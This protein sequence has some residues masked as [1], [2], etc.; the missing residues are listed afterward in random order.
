M[1]ADQ[2]KTGTTT[3]NG[4]HVSNVMWRLVV[5]DLD[6]ASIVIEPASDSEGRPNGSPVYL[7]QLEYEPRSM[8]LKFG[9]EI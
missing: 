6:T 9:R 5:R 8:N 2:C 4:G 1:I 3:M 7:V